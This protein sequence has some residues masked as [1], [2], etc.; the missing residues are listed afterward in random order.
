M[1]RIVKV[2]GDSMLPELNDGDYVITRKP[3]SIRP[4]FMY[5]VNHPD[6]GR[7]IK[8][9]ER[10]ENGKYFFVGANFKSVPTNVM[11]PVTAERI[12]GKVILRILKKAPK[13]L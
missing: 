7:I 11:G 10:T 5:V 12:V 8:W 4:G 1:I 9:L 3:R 13:T 6:L 2:V